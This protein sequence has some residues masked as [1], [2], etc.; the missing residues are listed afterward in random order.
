VRLALVHLGTDEQA[1]ELF[2]KFGLGDV[3]RFSDPKAE[4]YAEYHLG[5]GGA[6]EIFAPRV[7][8]RALGAL[9]RGHGVGKPVGDP[10][11]MPGAF[12]LEKGEIKRAFRPEKVSDR[13]DYEALCRAE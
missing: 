11:Q 12:L 13:P 6:R 9:F 2:S 5:R 10:R 1:A 4:L 7:V 8:G 3:A